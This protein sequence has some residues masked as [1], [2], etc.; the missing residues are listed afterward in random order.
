MD[1]DP[2]V[3]PMASSNAK[4]FDDETLNEALQQAIAE[5]EETKKRE[6]A[7]AQAQ[8]QAAENEAAQQAQLQEKAQGGGPFELG[9]IGNNLQNSIEAPT[10]V[11]GGLIDFTDDTVEMVGK[12]AG[13]DWEFLPDDWGPQNKTPWGKALRSIVSF[14]GPTVGLS[15]LTRAGIS[16]LTRLAGKQAATGAV[17]FIGKMGVDMAAGTAVDVINRNNEGDNLIRVL[18]DNIGGAVG[19]IPD[20]WATLDTDSP[21]V[22][23]NKNI[24]EGA[25]F[26]LLGSIIEG[27]VAWARALRG[28]DIGTEFIPKDA[29]A[30]KG[31]Q[32]V[33]NKSP[34][35]KS[36]HPMID[37]ILKDETYRSQHID[38]MAEVELKQYGG[39]INQ[40]DQFVPNIH[41]QIADEV[42]TL[43][44]AVRPD[45]MAQHMVDTVRIEKNIETLDGRAS[46][47]LTHSA[48]K[49]IGFDDLE[50]RK[51][52]KAIEKS[53][54][55]LGNFEAKL[56]NGRMMSNKEMLAAGDNLAATILDP[57]LTGKDLHR[58]FDRFDLRDVKEVSP[59]AKVYPVTDT[60]RVGAERALK[61]L[62]SLYLN[63]DTARASAYFQAS[64]AG[65]IAD[66]A[67]ASRVIGDDVDVTYIQ[68]RIMEKME[69]LWYEVEMN[70]S[71]AGWAL[72]NQKTFGELTK[73]GDN[74]GIKKLAEAAKRDFT[75]N[76]RTKAEGH[77]AFVDT[78]LK[79]NRSNP[80][81]LKP[82]M[83]AYELTNGDVNSIHK[84]NKYMANT[85]GVVN[86]AFYDGEPQIPSQVIQ[87]L[88]STFYNLK[89]SS[90]M[91]PIKAVANNFALLLMKPANVMLG[92]ALR[93]DGQT[94]HRAWVQYATQ[95]DTTM[96]ASADYMGMVFKKVSRDPESTAR[97]ADFITTNKEVVKAAREYAEA[98]AKR[99]NYSALHKVNFVET[100]EKINNHPWVRY[101]MNFMESGDAFTK[102]ALGMA[103]ARGQAFDKLIQE[104][105]PITGKDVK[106][107]ADKIYSEMFDPDGLMKDEAVKYAAGEI[108]MNLDTPLSSKLNDVLRSS[109]LLKT[110]VLFPRTSMNVLEFAHKHSPLSVFMGEFRKI[111]ELKEIDEI[112]QYLGAKGI[113]YTDA[114]WQAYKAEVQGRVAMGTALLTAAGWAYA[115]GNL[116]GNG[117]Y[118][119]QINRFQQNAGERPLRSFKGLD[120]KWYSYDGIE[121]IATFMGIAADILENHE[122]LGSTNSEALLQKL[123]FALSMNLTNKSFLQGLQPLTELLNGQPA[124]ISRWASNTAS[125]GL[126]TQMSRVMMP[127]LR[128]VD[129]DLQSMLRNKWN[130]LD[131]VGM[132]KPL[133]YKYDF[134]DGSIVGRADD[135]LTNLFNNLL[136][137]KVNSNPSPVKQ[138]L[139]DTEF[140]VQPAM[141]TSLKGATYDAFQR[142][143]LAQIMGESGYF[144]RGLEKLMNDKRIQED[145]ILIQ[146]ARAAGITGED[147]DLSNS[148]THR[149][150]RQLLTQSLNHAK[151][152][153]A[154]EIPEIRMSELKGLRTKQAQGRGDY[155]AILQMQ[156]K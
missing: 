43:P 37:R 10:A 148:Y 59:G 58:L 4:S 142:S 155:G 154:D 16:G 136:P 54:K 32:E 133:P 82:L 144:R 95:M 15:S 8:Q 80:E 137:F 153:L 128:E 5:D 99:G 61:E 86:K 60:A 85:L 89:L 19:W 145:M 42:E 34:V 79:M 84:L 57:T 130:V 149:K 36:E 25:G 22:K 64:Q 90:V 1:Y 76:V 140:D 56:P 46:D 38:E 147:A 150:I 2:I 112:T 143:R 40:V 97:R 104:G 30:V 129:N 81:Y 47:F 92:A 105:R 134:I 3:E 91:T 52:I 124:A 18:K 94:M 121:P 13:Q 24:L 72:Q 45:G 29:Q 75:T 156:N 122:T 65:E 131:A 11:V 120:G 106:E 138:F 71:V 23:K 17:N 69:A 70:K 102:S 51:L 27:G 111:G 93:G 7:I 62:K 100:M 152:Q 39:D 44:K 14:V 6:Q 135:P 146:T 125:I 63:M 107:V 109:P 87:G 55:N 35:T 127:G 118:D 126:F 132:G 139:I 12:L 103:E 78:L 151:R 119:K 33:T 116:S 21:D 96:K 41:S 31:L 98:E 83:R 68:Q 77:A 141:K 73:A 117:N 101:S 113:K 123:G 20:D 50:G 49:A 110:L 9:N 108:A 114:T 26:G 74:A 53:I 48:V 66:M 88:F 115:S 67:T 28:A